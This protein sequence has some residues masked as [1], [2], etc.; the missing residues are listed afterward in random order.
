M[1]F[2]FHTFPPLFVNIVD[3]LDYPVET[4]NILVLVNSYVLSALVFGIIIRTLLIYYGDLYVF[5][6]R[7]RKKHGKASLVGGNSGVSEL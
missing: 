7:K 3:I 6:Y 1:C 5:D 4:V 2:T